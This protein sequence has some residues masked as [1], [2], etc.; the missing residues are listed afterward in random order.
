[1]AQSLLHRLARR[2]L[3]DVVFVRTLPV[4][5]GGA[6]LFVS[7]ESQL[8]YLKPGA[9][10]FDA[11]LLRL[12][13]ELVRPGM[14]VW[15]IG[16]NI[17]VFS[18]AAA[19]RGARSL[20][21]EPDPVLVN[22]LLRSRALKANKALDVRIAACAISD[23]RGL[24][25]FAISAEGRAA[26]SLSAFLG[27]RAEAGLVRD[28]FLVAIVTLDDLLANSPTPDIV[29]IDVERAE[30]AVL[31][32]ASHLLGNVKPVLICECGRPRW[33]T[34]ATILKS[35][36]YR[37]YDADVAARIEIDSFAFNTLA[38]PAR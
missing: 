29:K 19:A 21:V 18:F 30:L 17:G 25:N 12:A 13:E 34:M 6:R 8:K 24:A 15:D 36:G 1:M 16:A 11:S 35:F 22:L 32:G 2:A 23:T 3:R 14:T 27:G 9:A 20:A 4:A 26:N 5:F 38:I 31:Q 28:E 37:L 33:N 10:G 7:P